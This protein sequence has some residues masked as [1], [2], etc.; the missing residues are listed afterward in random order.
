MLNGKGKYVTFANKNFAVLMYKMLE[1]D[2]PA[3]YLVFT[4]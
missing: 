2:F 3:A 4:F 1:F